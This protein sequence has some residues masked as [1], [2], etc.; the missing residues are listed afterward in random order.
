MAIY[1]YLPAEPYTKL[2]A[3]DF[4][5]KGDFAQGHIVTPFFGVLNRNRFMGYVSH[6]STHHFFTI[7]A[8]EMTSENRKK[9]IKEK[10]TNY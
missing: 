5:P 3:L 2:L 8:M 7:E 1:G 6:R 4:P 9:T 10:H